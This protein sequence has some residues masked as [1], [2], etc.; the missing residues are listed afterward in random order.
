MTISEG[1]KKVWLIRR[2]EISL[3]LT[4][5]VDNATIQ[6]SKLA[7]FIYEVMNILLRFSSSYWPEVSPIEQIFCA[8]KSKLVSSECKGANNFGTLRGL[9]HIANWLWELSN[10]TWMG[11]WTNVCQ[12]MKRTIISTDM[13]NS[14]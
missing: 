4:I 13:K 8:L 6:S 1:F 3:N 11:A 5:L 10:E 7:K 9:I 2:R 14:D 12:E